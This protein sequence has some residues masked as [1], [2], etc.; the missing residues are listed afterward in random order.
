MPEPNS[1]CWLW[2]G[3]LNKV[4]GYGGVR[5]EGRRCVSAHRAYYLKHRG[6][7]P[8]GKELDHTCRVRSCVN[9]WHLEA[10]TRAVNDRRRP[11][12]RL[13]TNAVAEIRALVAEG[14][15]QKAVAARFGVH[16]SHISKI[17]SR[18]KW[19]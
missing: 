19:A 17:V 9:P 13:T 6:P 15:E 1:G 7:V 3:H 8:D 2:L 14:T 11:A 16:K 10:V 5:I 4:T 12:T 18:R